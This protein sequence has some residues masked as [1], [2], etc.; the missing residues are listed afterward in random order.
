MHQL[1]VENNIEINEDLYP[2]F[3]YWMTE[4]Q[5][6]F[7]KRLQ[8]FDPPYSDDPVFQKYKFTNVY[9]VLDR[10][11]QF[12]VKTIQQNGQDYFAPE[13]LFMRTIFFKFF[14][15]LDWWE[16]F[17]VIA[18]EPTIK[19]FD[20]QKYKDV[21]DELRKTKKLYSGAYMMSG[22][23]G[24]H[25]SRIKHHNHVDVID[26]LINDEFFEK[27][28][29]VE[30][31]EDL[32][33][34]LTSVRFIGNFVAMQFATDI[35]YIGYHKFSEDDFIICG[36]GAHRGV[37][38]IF[39]KLPKNMKIFDVIKLLH[40][41]QEDELKDFIPIPGHMPSVMDI[42]NCLCEVD[43]YTRTIEG[44]NNFGMSRI[45]S[46]FYKNNS[47]IEYVLPAWWGISENVFES[48]KTNAST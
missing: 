25:G 36:P 15:R 42:Q 47:Q 41:V 20:A 8:G 19:S 6:I 21:L 12:V 31:Y 22:A 44:V 39:K 18:G 2:Y 17:V 37:L 5:N 1:F 11:S 7:V 27:M 43:K 45:K 13:D 30:S 24:K 32:W 9:R 26:Q 28:L 29:D 16:E 35:N 14:N 34:L 48:M 33:K 40:A 38:K 3:W 4:R 10:V 46:R 23:K